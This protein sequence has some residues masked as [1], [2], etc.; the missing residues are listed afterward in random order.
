MAVSP[1]TARPPRSPSP[2]LSKTS[3]SIQCDAGQDDST[4]TSQPFPQPPVATILSTDVERGGSHFFPKHHETGG[5]GLDEYEEE[6]TFDATTGKMLTAKHREKHDHPAP[7]DTRRSGSG[8]A[9]AAGPSDN[10][11]TDGTESTA[12]KFAKTV[13]KWILSSPPAVQDA[14]Q[15]ALVLLAGLKELF[16]VDP[17]V[18][19]AVAAAG[20]GL[21]WWCGHNSTTRPIASDKTEI[22][23]D[24]APSLLAQLGAEGPPRH[25]PPS[26]AMREVQA[27]IALTASLA[28]GLMYGL[29]TEFILEKYLAHVVSVTPEPNGPPMPPVI[30]YG[31]SRGLMI[32]LSAVVGAVCKSDSL[33]TKAGWFTLHGVRYGDTTIAKVTD[34]LLLERVPYV[35]DGR[36]IVSTISPTLHTI[37]TAA[38]IT[39][40]ISL[41]DGGGTLVQQAFTVILG[42]LGGAGAANLQRGYHEPIGEAAHTPADG[43]G[44]AGVLTSGARLF[45]K[46]AGTVIEYAGGLAPLASLLSPKFVTGASQL[47]GGAG[48]GAAIGQLTAP[49]VAEAWSAMGGP[50]VSSVSMDIGLPIAL[51]TLGAAAALATAVRLDSRTLDG[52]RVGNEPALDAIFG[53][54]PEPTPG[55]SSVQAYKERVESRAKNAVAV[56]ASAVHTFPQDVLGRTPESKPAATPATP[57][58]AAELR[59]LL[60]NAEGA[61]AV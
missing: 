16:K 51:G 57:S 25:V 59:Q 43:R 20:G 53:A 28:T 44:M 33:R 60:I 9:G 27:A 61:V 46:T 37:L 6:F 40:A 14:A 4:Q 1:V 50:G 42:A 15:T 54:P 23:K 32:A 56:L 38:G 19:T 55:S 47:V 10:A 41:A 5:P 52:K 31:I 17:Y 26:R 49:A 35:I 39:G 2:P 12:A 34:L 48:M 29:G 11:Q 30:I 3:H 45:Q 7:S 24:P 8:G 13:L 21:V 36:K 58:T 22:R 18:A